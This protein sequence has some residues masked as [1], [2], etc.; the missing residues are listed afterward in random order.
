MKPR[1]I[2]ILGPTATGKSALA[3][4]LSERFK[5]EIIN[6]DSMQVYRFMDIGTAKPH[7]GA[8]R[9]VRHHLI[10]VAD[11]DE[12][13]TAGRF[14]ED[15]RNAIQDII[16]RGKLPLV[17]GG[18]G[19]YIRALTEG[20]FNGP[21]RDPAIRAEL[22]E[23]AR[24]HGNLYLHERL[25]EIDPESANVIHPNNLQRIIRAIEVY[26]LKKRAISTLHK[27]EAGEPLPYETL[28]IG[29]EKER[30]CLYADIDRRVE[31]MIQ[32]GL[33]EET[34]RLM[35]RGYDESNAAMGGLGY[36]ECLQ[37]LR[38][39]DDITLEKTIEL[40][41]RDTRHYAKRQITW[42]KKDNEIKWFNP[43]Q[44]ADI[45]SLV[46]KFLG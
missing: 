13:Y 39:T 44:K 33:V 28:K 30:P 26:R 3:Q 17:T 22:M 18:T 9:A 29:L 6:A 45:I 23:E 5:G 46:D 35:E 2:I 31:E 12:Q 16:S 8:R 34:A 4:E 40:I 38:C 25:K 32:D 43:G 1:I 10:D 27:E 36:K 20:L 41:K 7:K 15:A 21:P 24:I 19:L 14:C 37:Y 42:F 11:P